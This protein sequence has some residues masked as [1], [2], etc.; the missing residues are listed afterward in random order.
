LPAP[1]GVQSLG[2]GDEALATDAAEFSVFSEISPRASL[3]CPS[4]VNSAF[5]AEVAEDELERL[6][7]CTPLLSRD[8]RG[9]RNLSGDLDG[10][11]LSIIPSAS[12]YTQHGGRFALFGFGARSS[13][14]RV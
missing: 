13:T 5:L 9:G 6:R 8:E 3:R 11:A 10:D 7:R 12:G 1:C 4:S 14:V 2:G